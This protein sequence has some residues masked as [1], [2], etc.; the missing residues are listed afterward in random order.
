RIQDSRHI[1]SRTTNYELRT[2][3]KHNSQFT[4]HNSQFTFLFVAFML[5]VSMI[6]FAA[7]KGKLPLPL[8]S[9]AR[10][11]PVSKETRLKLLSLEEAMVTLRTTDDLYNKYK[12]ELD[13]M[14]SLY[15][16]DVVTG[17]EVTEAETRFKDAERRLEMARI[18]LAKT[19]L[20]FLQDATHLSTMSAYQYIDAD[21][22]RM[23]A[24]TLKNT[25]DLRLAKLGLG[26]GIPEAGIKKEN[27][28]D[29]L[30]IEDLFVSVK[31]GAT[32]IGEPYEIKVPSLPLGAE[33]TLHFKLKAD[34]DEVTLVLQYQNQQETQ[35]IYLEKRSG[36]DIVRVISMQFAQEGEL[37]NWVNYD[38]DLERLAED[39]KTFTLEVMN[40]PERYQYKFT[41]KGTQISRVKFLQGVSKRPLVLKIF[42]PDTIPDS[43]LNRS[44]R[45][46]A[47]VGDD[48][49]IAAI[50]EQKRRT[51]SEISAEELENL[52]VGYE[53][54]ELIPR[55]V[56]KMEI[57]FATLYYEVKVGE[58]INPKMKLK[59]TGSVVLNNV[60]FK[61]EKQTEWRVEY[62]PKTIT[63]I[64]PREEVRVDVTVVPPPNAEV[65]AYEIKA[66]AETEH[67]GTTVQTEQK[68]LRLQVSGR[69]NLLGNILLISVLI[70]A[71]IGIAVFTVRLSRR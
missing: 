18:T 43:D 60:R 14:Q 38:L 44:I 28:T 40:L 1:E 6:T 34:A 36:E 64:K 71:V 11:A 51:N 27:L 30:T 54:L 8:P 45:F 23:M 7:E 53:G 61:T 62:S 37:G 58:T 12:K 17:K 67:E 19:A 25:S 3:N 47:L 70:V 50:R 33:T 20:A 39:E 16:E 65:G 10:Q 29:L 22:N 35:N 41:D 4:I 52:K 24:V 26:D 69:T 13:D 5:C 48:D 15:K 59:N 2:T 57:S 66:Q 9:S 56:G 63:E 68:N 21:G 46:F 55:G 32:V 31:S 42:V 49:A